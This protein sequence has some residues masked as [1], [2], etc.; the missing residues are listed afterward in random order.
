MMLKKKYMRRLI[1]LMA[2]IVLSFS[3]CDEPFKNSMLKAYDDDPI[4]TWLEKH[5][6]YSDWVAVLN[7]TELF[8]TMNISHT[9]MTHF[10]VKNTALQAYAEEKGYSHILDMTDDDLHKLIQSHTIPNF[11]ISSRN[12]SGKISRKT[13][14]RDYLTA[15]YDTES[16]WRYIL[17]G[18]DLPVSTF[19]ESDIETINGYIHVLD[20]P[21]NVV[22]E[23]LWQVLEEDGKF[24]IFCEALRQ[25]GL[26]EYLK[27]EYYE[28]FLGPENDRVKQEVK[29]EKTVFAVTDEIYGDY[30]ISSYE[31]LKKYL[32]DQAESVSDP[33]DV[34]GHLYQY[35]AYHIFSKKLGYADLLTFPLDPYVKQDGMTYLKKK[36]IYPMLT[37]IA[38]LKGISVEDRGAQVVFNPH[39]SSFRIVNKDIPAFNGYIHTIDNIMEKPEQ[40]AFFPV[41]IELTDRIEFTAISFYRDYI[42]RGATARTYD[43]YNGDI[44]GYE[45][46]SLSGNAKVWY[47]SIWEEARKDTDDF[48]NRYMNQDLLYWDLGVQGRITFDFPPLPISGANNSYRFYAEKANDEYKGGIYN[49]ALGQVIVGSD[50]NFQKGGAMA[51]LKGFTVMAETPQKLTFSISKAAGEA[52]VDRLILM[53]WNRNY[54]AGDYNSGSPIY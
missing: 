45:W 11:E 42:D 7:K 21:I 44:E 3:S 2:G 16:D 24:S 37:E 4:A 41:E 35:V 6:D 1:Y 50:I 27:N 34:R 49:A 13:A 12:M 10:V 20:R 38:F 33:L 32:D 18:D 54:S 8:S 30:S 39:A 46:S 14:L 26:D 23:N 29:E 53:P 22:S 51:A 25:T 43:F 17:N 48:P 40:M 5:A 52:G 28:F 9:V 36:I 19:I 15:V 47:A 31:E